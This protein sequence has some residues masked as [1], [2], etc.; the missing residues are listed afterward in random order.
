WPHGC[1]ARIT[2]CITAFITLE[3]CLCITV[4]LKV[5]E[6]ITPKR[7]IAINIF[8]FLLMFCILSPAFY[9]DRFGPVSAPKRNKTLI[10]LVFVED[11]QFIESICKTMDVSVQLISF[12]IVSISTAILIQNLLRNTKWRMSMSKSSTSGSGQDMGSRD[13]K[14]V[15]MVLSISCMFIVCFLPTVINYIVMF[16]FPSYSVKGRYS[17][18]FRFVWALLKIL[19]AVHSSATIFIYFKM[20]TKYRSVLKQIIC[21]FTQHPTDATHNSSTGTTREKDITSETLCP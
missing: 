10:G 7:T 12:V 19:E 20:S 8:V 14:V 6:I 15:R 16:I 21:V 18:T 5:K 11:G 17:N 13:K 4:P 9:A 1:F 3:R 2:S